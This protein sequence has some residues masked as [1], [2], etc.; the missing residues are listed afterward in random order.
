MKRILKWIGILSGALLGLILLLL[1]GVWLISSNRFKQ[2]YQVTAD[3]SLTVPDDA[4]S[5]AE[6][7]RLYAI[8]C[9]EC[10]GENL[11]G[12]ELFN[13]AVLGHIRS[14]NLTAGQGGIAQTYSNED[15]AR[16]VWYGVKADG[17]PAAVMPVEYKD[18]QVGDME[19]LL[20]YIRSVPPVDSSP[21]II[22]PGVLLWVMHA[23]NLFPMLPAE[24][25]DMSKPPVQAINTADTL[26][27]G[28]Y[29]TMT[30]T[31]CHGADFAGG[32]M[33]EPSLRPVVS[34]WTEAE[35][36]QALRT[37]QRPDGTTLNNKEMP[38]PAFSNFTD[39]EIQTIWTYLQSVQAVASTE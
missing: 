7:Q 35:F 33:G 16:A 2:T 20:A 18:L 6:G 37:G 28:K 22:K 14:T 17:S 1:V 12:T 15:I 5:I 32:D 38:W 25:R 10:H 19:K 3:F 36:R 11:A 23:T 34:T 8:M 26:A 31:G 9:A 39:A 4:D 30:C 24:S 21:A 29:L 13:D 27:Y